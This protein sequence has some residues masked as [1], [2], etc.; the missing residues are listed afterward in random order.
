MGRV[1]Q[2]LASDVCVCVFPAAHHAASSDG[3]D[4]NTA[5]RHLRARLLAAVMWSFTVLAMAIVHGTLLSP[6]P[7]LMI[8]QMFVLLTSVLLCARQN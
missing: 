8:C 6:L 1:L 3:A 2:Q 7:V 4:I 5:V